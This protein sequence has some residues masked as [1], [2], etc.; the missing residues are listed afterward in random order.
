[1]EAGLQYRDIVKYED[2]LVRWIE[3]VDDETAYSFSQILNNMINESRDWQ[4]DF[5]GSLDAQVIIENLKKISSEKL[6]D[7]AVFLNR[8]LYSRK[9]TWT[10]EFCKHLPKQEVSI[11]MQKCST[12]RIGGLSEMLC[13]LRIINE[14]FCFDEYNKCIPIINHSMKEGFIYTLEELGLNFLMYILGE[15]LFNLGRPNQKQKDAGR[16]FV[17][18]ITTSMIEECIFKG[19]PR[20]WDT[21][22]RFS[23]EVYRYDPQKFTHAIRNADL[24]I[25]NLRTSDMWERQTDELIELL[26]MLYR[27]DEAKTDEWIFLHRD[28]MKDIEPSLTQF[29]PKTAEYVYNNGGSVILAKPFR[30]VTNANAI[31]RLNKYNRN[32]CHT[33]IY[34]CIADIKQSV[35][36]LAT[37]DWDEY[38]LFLRELIEVDRNIISAIFSDIDMPLIEEK[39]NNAL[40]TDFYKHQKKALQGFQRATTLIKDNIKD[41]SIVT[42]MA[43][44]SEKIVSA[45]GRLRTYK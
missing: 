20:D 15:G 17:G 14:A 41:P 2:F 32:L 10:R 6:Y 42:S 36:N 38:H 34:A 35:Y 3:N 9:S 37:I 45:L 8:L 18:C 7:W 39:W 16:T 11:A 30:W 5:V 27:C 12:Q 23:G 28:E 13:S 24:S 40:I 33:V 22:Y 43:R 1:M 26:Y 4:N 31:S 21:L 44:I 25:L 29:S 19:T